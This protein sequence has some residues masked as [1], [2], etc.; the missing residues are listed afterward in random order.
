MTII[1]VSAVQFA[2]K[3]IK[4]FKDFEK[5][6]K[7]LIGR[8]VGS[9]FIIFPEAFTL[10]FQYLIL[11]YDISR[12]Y[13][14]TEDYLNLFARLSKE[15]NQVIIAGSHIILENELRYNTG[16]IFCPD[17]TIL[18]HRKSHIMPYEY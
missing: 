3:P 7:N 8:A 16:F 5:N 13:E 4:I 14:F 1:K 11:K 17:G 9:D 15:N 18:N 10:E 6:V 2:Y 12:L